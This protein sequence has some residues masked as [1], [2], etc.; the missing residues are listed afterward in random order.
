MSH[1]DPIFGAFSRHK[2]GAV[3]RRGIR[4]YFTFEE[5]VRWWEENLGPDWMTK[6]GRGRDQYCMARKGDKGPYAVWN[7]DCLTNRQNAIDGLKN[8]PLNN[9]GEAH[10]RARLS[11]E[12]VLAIFKSKKKYRIIAAQF[13]I[14]KGHVECIKRGSRWGSVTGKV[15][16]QR[17]GLG[18]SGGLSL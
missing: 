1:I 15:K 17:K 12:D 9:K 5:W 16:P 18:S 13:G 10:G 7:V 4:F 2:R 6:R 3:H 8:H 14:T 11:N